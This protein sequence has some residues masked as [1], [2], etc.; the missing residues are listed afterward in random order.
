MVISGNF[1]RFPWLKKTSLGNL[2][3]FLINGT[4]HVLVGNSIFG[5]TIGLDSSIG[6]YQ[7]LD[8]QTIET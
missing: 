2:T 6:N 5:N 4:I 8:D 7:Q 1:R 3:E